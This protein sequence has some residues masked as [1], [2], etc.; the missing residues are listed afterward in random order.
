MAGMRAEN[1]LAGREYDSNAVISEAEVA[2]MCAAIPRPYDKDLYAL[3]YLVENA[4][5]FLPEKANCPQQSP[6]ACSNRICV[7]RVCGGDVKTAMDVLGLSS[8]LF[9]DQ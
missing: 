5:L 6:N 3:R 1:L 4:F 7:S 2:G 9:L 8:G